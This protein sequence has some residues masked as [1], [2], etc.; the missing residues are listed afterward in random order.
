METGWWL[1]LFREDIEWESYEKAVYNVSFECEN[2]KISE[3]CSAMSQDGD[4][5]IKTHRDTNI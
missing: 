3:E 1:D 4:N 5:S 2:A